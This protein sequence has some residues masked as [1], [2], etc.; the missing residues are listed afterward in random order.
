MISNVNHRTSARSL[1]PVRH[2][3]RVPEVD[4][5]LVRQAVPDLRQ[6]RQPANTRIENPNGPR[7]THGT[8]IQHSGLSARSLSGACQHGAFGALSARLR[9][10]K[11]LACQQVSFYPAGLAW[12]RTTTAT[13]GR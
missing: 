5:V 2:P 6:H 8:V 11:A 12:P 9:A 3:R 13:G 7:I 1:H 10:F 4:G